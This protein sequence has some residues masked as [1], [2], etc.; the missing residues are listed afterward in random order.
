MMRIRWHF[1]WSDIL[2]AQSTSVSLRGAS[3][4]GTFPVLTAFSGYASLFGTE[5]QGGDIVMP[6]AFRAAVAE[7]GATGI[8]MLFQHDPREPIGV[9]DHI[10]EDVRGLFVRGHLIEDSPRAREIL[11]L[12]RGGALD[13]LSIGF[14]ARRAT[15][16]ARTG[17]RRLYDIDL[18][19]I[20]IVTFPMLPGARVTAFV[21]DATAAFPPTRSRKAADPVSVTA[22]QRTL[23]TAPA[24]ALSSAAAQDRVGRSFTEI[25]ARG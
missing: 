16:D 8:R 12:I 25:T 19:E 24:A 11:A 20:S 18:W 1:R 22:A 5:D 14:R 4:A 17:Q 7:R 15:R 3:P 10:T 2:P 13:G 9:W 6:G 21:S 23:R